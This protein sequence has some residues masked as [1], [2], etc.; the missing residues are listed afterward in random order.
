M[1]SRM[2]ANSRR[3]ADA[4]YWALIPAAGIGKRFGADIPKQYLKVLGMTVLEHTLRRFCAHEKIAGIVVALAADD[5][6]WPELRLPPRP[7]IHTAV[8]GAERCHSVL[9]A[10][11]AVGELAAPDDWV[12]VHDA[13]RPCLR[14][15]DID[16]LIDTLG[17]DPVG[18][19]LAAPVRDTM[20]RT[21]A[22]LG[23]TE[24]VE[25]TRL[26]HALTPQMFRCRLL[27]GAI[28]RAVDQGR[29]ITDEAQAVELAGHRARVVEGRPDNV[30][31][32][33][34]QDLE[35]AEF[36]LKQQREALSCA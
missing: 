11:K 19:I 20:K 2:T 34:A 27:A 32:T 4:R 1:P 26:W 31:I 25:R 33:H 8:G 10:L 6:Y 15:S 21:D 17:G 9:N 23:I 30:K 22:A 29:L 7:K 14:A 16:R 36:Y 28:E 18:G 13:A 5:C 24:T 3:H 35:L 12:L